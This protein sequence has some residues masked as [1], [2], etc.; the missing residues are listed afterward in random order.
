MSVMA[1]GD[2]NGYL[3]RKVPN[4]VMAF[5]WS[6]RCYS[7]GPWANAW[8]GSP[9]ALRDLFNCWSETFQVSLHELQMRLVRERR[10]W[11]HE[12]STLVLTEGA[13]HSSLVESIT[14]SWLPRGCGN[15]RMWQWGLPVI[16]CPRLQTSRDPEPV[17]MVVGRV[18]PGGL[19]RHNYEIFVGEE[20]RSYQSDGEYEYF[21][22]PVPFAWTRGIP[23]ALTDEL[24]G[25]LRQLQN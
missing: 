23:W 1:E 20:A 8:N 3:Q 5:S 18:R 15:W 10:T 14:A 21:N 7:C 6:G 25:R 24:K 22:L 11:E 4:D 2:V 16:D 13:R 12:R 17:M 19:E 9:I